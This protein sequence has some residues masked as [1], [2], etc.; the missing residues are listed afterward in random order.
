MFDTST[1]KRFED[2]KVLG[3]SDS[4]KYTICEH[5]VLLKDGSLKTIYSKRTELGSVYYYEN[6]PAIEHPNHIR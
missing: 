6:C 1:I 5:L 2:T 4:F 3:Y